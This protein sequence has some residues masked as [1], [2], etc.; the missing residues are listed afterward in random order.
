MPIKEYDI[1]QPAPA[2]STV[3]RPS[4]LQEAR[5]MIQPI[6]LIG[7]Y[8]ELSKGK[9][10]NGERVMLFSGWKSHETVMFL[11]KRYLNRLGYDTQYWGLG[12]NNGYVERYRDKII[13]KLEKETSQ[14]KITLIG[15]SLGGL[16]A[17]E[18]ARVIPHK[19]AS[20]ITYGTPAIGGPKY[21]IG[22]NTYEEKEVQRIIDLQAELDK[23][24]P[25]KVPMSIIFT[26]NDSIVNW[27]ACIDW[28]S[29][30][31]KHYEVNSSH[32]SLGIDP[33][34][35]KIIVQELENRTI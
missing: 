23:T 14:E 26:K 8:K 21:T 35:W 9:A 1:S 33:N 32:L 30:N 12:F 10:G 13:S 28:K 20:I 31:V 17:R 22:V 29:K 15:W 2:P 24:N 3:K 7:S 11:L 27:S 16:I 19:I 18:V 5:V 6:R 34:V 4:L 25:I